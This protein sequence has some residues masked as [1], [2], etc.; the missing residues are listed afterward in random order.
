MPIEV[1]CPSCG[2]GVYEESDFCPHCGVLRSPAGRPSCPEHPH[3][4]AEHV[5][6]ICHRL[7]CPRC[8]KRKQGKSFCAEHRKVEVVLDWA[9]V[10]QSDEV[11]ES[12]LIRSVLKAGG[13][14]VQQQNFDAGGNVWGTALVR[15]AKVFVP[16]PEY[17][18]ARDLVE[19]WVLQSRSGRREIGPDGDE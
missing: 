16:I 5:C 12:D 17:L 11:S 9:N 19:G 14:T 2:E 3:R 10:F 8:R 15:P 13:F 18:K 7:L 4:T 1:H 6:I